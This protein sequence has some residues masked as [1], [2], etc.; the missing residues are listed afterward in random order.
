MVALVA[1]MQN[2]LVAN[3]VM[4][5]TIRQDMNKIGFTDIAVSLAIESLLGKEMVIKDT[6][7]DY[8]EGEYVVYST[9]PQGK[10]WLLN[11]QDKLVLKR[12]NDIPF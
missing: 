9:S 8:R 11:N 5:E 3:E 1:V 2:Q 4:P 6:V 10:R 12:S 7:Q